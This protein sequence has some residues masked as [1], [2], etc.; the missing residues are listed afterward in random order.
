MHAA[1]IAFLTGSNTIFTPALHLRKEPASGKTTAPPA[2]PV[3]VI[4]GLPATSCSF[5]V[6]Q[7]ATVQLFG[8]HN[9]VAPV[10][11]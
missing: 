2:G 1:V 4:W 6:D 5:H 8:T 7:N 10:T 3:A 11:G 9:L